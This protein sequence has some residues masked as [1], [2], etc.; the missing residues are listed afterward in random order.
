MTLNFSEPECV[1]KI[2]GLLIFVNIY[3]RFVKEL[4]R[5][6]NLLTNMIK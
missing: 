5:I 3:C 4:L 6:A 2:K 1:C